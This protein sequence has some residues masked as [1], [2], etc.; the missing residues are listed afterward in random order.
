MKKKV[1]TLIM[2]L[3]LTVGALTACGNKNGAPTGVNSSGGAET[4]EENS[5]D[6]DASTGKKEEPVELKW[7]IRFDDQADTAKVNEE[8]NKL[9]L[10]KINCTVEISNIPGGTYNDKMQVILGG[11]EE[12]DVVFAG[13]GFADFWGN[14][15]RGAFLPLNDLLD[16]YGKETYNNIPESLWNGVKVNGDIYGVINYQIE[17]KEAGFYV[18]TEILNKYNFDLSTVKKLEDIE[19]LLEQVHKDD[20][21]IIPIMVNE[22]D[23]LPLMGYDEI[24]TQNSPGAVAIGDDS[25]TVVNQYE[26]EGWQN[27]VKLIRKWYEAGYIAADAATM[28]SGNDLIK[29][30]KVAVFLNNMKPGGEEEQEIL[31]G[32]DLTV[33]K[34]MDGRVLPSAVSATL[35]CISSTNKHPE[36]AMEFINLLNTDKDVYNL[37]C[38]GIEGVHYNKVGDNRIELVENS[39]YQPNKAWA[40]GNQ[41]N[42][43]LQSTQSDTVWEDTMA[44]NENS[45]V[46]E[47]LGFVFDQEAVKSQVAQCQSVI[48]QYFR[49]I[50][51]GTVDPDTY[52]P[53][54]LEK[55]KLAGVDDIIAEKQA[56]LNTWKTSK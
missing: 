3:V 8:L 26:T 43:Y 50:V 42:A 49:S 55:L 21:T 36:K 6:T 11:R 32:R 53:E 56:Q 34:I 46:S 5:K 27:Y 1:L 14:T 54:F 44:L 7:Y 18:P 48:D 33:Q 51:R 41:F 13:A 39:G 2:G 9:L 28:D 23:L 12:C 31:W 25:L 40:M 52:I 45:S 22:V 47:L 15:T 4:S 37:V 17:A 19:P 24:G 38:F 35:Q 30:G 10:E 20:P 29:A 16:K